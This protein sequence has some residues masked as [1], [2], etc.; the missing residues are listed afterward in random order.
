MDKATQAALDNIL[1]TI[2]VFHDMQISPDD[3]EAVTQ[4]LRQANRNLWGQINTVEAMIPINIGDVEAEA[5]TSLRAMFEAG[6][7]K[8]D[9]KAWWKWRNQ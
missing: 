7:L 9:R 8:V 1:N 5:A 6:V 2:N 3:A 4:T